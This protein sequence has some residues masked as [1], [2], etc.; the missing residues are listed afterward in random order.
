M[1]VTSHVLAVE[2]SRAGHCAIR[3]SGGKYSDA[4]LCAAAGEV[5][6]QSARWSAHRDDHSPFVALLGDWTADWV[7]TF[8]GLASCGWAVGVLDPTWSADEVAGALAQLDPCAIL[9]AQ[10]QQ[11]M[12][13]TDGWYRR[14]GGLPGWA[15]LTRDD[16]GVTAPPPTPDSPFY[17]GFTSGSSGR[18]KAFVRSHRSWWESFERFSEVCPIDA[19][20]TVLVPGPLSSS[21][22]LFGALHALHVGATVQ[23]VTSVEYSPGHVARQLA[24]SPPPN[25]IY[26]VPTML[27]QQAAETGARSPEFIFCAGARLERSVRERA[28]RRFPDSRLV[29]YY[30][31]SELSFVAIQ[32]D[33]DGTPPG[34]V[35]RV[36]PGVEV[37]IRDDQDQSVAAGEPGIIWARS[38]LVFT[39][40]RGQA[41]AGGARTLPEGWLTVGDRG[42]LDTGG[43]L[44]VLGRGSALIITGGANVQP[45]EVEEV[46]AA[47]AGVAGC[48]VVGIPDATWGQIVC[49]VIT[50]AGPQAPSRGELRRHV[51]KHL[52][53]YKRPRRYVLIEG[54][55]P[56]GPSGK[57]DRGA[58]L[59][60]I[61]AGDGQD[62]S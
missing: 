32:V 43:Y 51:A 50:S 34:S 47:A 8:L 40:Y 28:A 33:G 1:L 49:A 20:G 58:V 41:P 14:S 12:T 56:L 26:V 46:V 29:E 38:D 61:Q 16:G 30:G 21:H 54:P 13:P 2:R 39:G 11:E 57:V 25:G 60:L 9:I 53:R 45:E 42:V 48:A 36:F 3:G 6:G 7:A 19:D 62:L 55:V 22:F 18:P 59:G 27:A 24:T 31:A 4:E 17:V 44:S 5:A 10:G 15:V 52:A 35:G 37:S 23:L